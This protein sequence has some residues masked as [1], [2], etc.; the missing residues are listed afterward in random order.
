M[1]KQ[2]LI[3]IIVLVAAIVV[4]AVI[5][6]SRPTGPGA[7]AE[8]P[9]ASGTVN[10]TGTSTNSQTGSQGGSPLFNVSSTVTYEAVGVS[11]PTSTEWMP[12][13][14]KSVQ[15]SFS[16]PPGWS[17]GPNSPISFDNF[18][19]EYLNGGIIPMGGAEIDITNTKYY[20][21]LTDLIKTETGGAA[22]TTKT[23]S[24]DGISCTEAFFAESYAPGYPSSNVSVYCPDSANGLL[25]KIYLSYRASDP[26]G[27]QYLSTFNQVLDSI[28]FTQ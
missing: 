6:F 12:Y 9:N 7:P 26:K 25:Y 14:S 16:Y 20:G 15:I 8:Q 19:H 4:V 28:K 17:L 2:T 10:T 1:K 5:G 27:S 23:V 22:Y 18:E 11:N 3:T 24:V 21:A 13:T